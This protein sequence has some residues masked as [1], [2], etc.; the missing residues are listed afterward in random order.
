MTWAIILAIAVA[1]FAVLVFV[2][3]MPRSAWE[4]AG[5]ALLFG[6]AGYAVQ[7][8][9]GMAGAP[10][11]AIENQR[12]ADAELLHQRQQMGD[13][14]GQGQSWL[15][16]S[17]A[18]SREGQFRAAADFL[19]SAVRR[20]PDDADL[21]V[22][23]GNALTGHSDGMITPAAQ[24]AFRRAAA[25][26][27]DHPGPPF[28]MGLALAQSGHLVEA[29]AMWAALLARTPPGA[30]FRADLAARLARLDQLIAL[31][32]GVA[33]A[34]AGARAAPDAAPDA[35]ESGTPAPEGR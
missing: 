13:A 9:P 19:G 17:D 7:G 31:S 8:H 10:K 5:A 29:R 27:P 24:F 12:T 2:L 32:E 23:L 34:G 1:V 16:V 20:H 21:W 25:I 30:P 18:L 6:L 14:F 33:P 28:F 15:V 4:I 11:A 26:N 3:K 35:G 22:A